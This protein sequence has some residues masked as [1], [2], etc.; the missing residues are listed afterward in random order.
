MTPWRMQC[1][2]VLPIS[3]E[4]AEAAF[5][6]GEPESICQA[7]VRVAFHDT[8]WRWVQAWCMEFARHSDCEVRGLAATCLGHLARIHRRLDL[9]AELPVL[10]EL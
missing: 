4:E 1:E 7:L 6:S 8:H 2:E 3:R 5:L 9:E 10:H